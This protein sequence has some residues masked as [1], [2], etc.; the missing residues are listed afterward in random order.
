MVTIVT[1]TQFTVMFIRTLLSCVCFIGS[2]DEERAL[3][4][5]VLRNLFCVPKVVCLMRG[6]E[7]E[8]FLRSQQFLS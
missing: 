3:T 2:Q 1:C 6:T 5:T 8:S 7:A 4:S